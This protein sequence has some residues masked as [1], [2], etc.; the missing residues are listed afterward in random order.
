MHISAKFQLHLMASEEMFFFV[1]VFFC[2]CFFLIFFCKFSPSV[3]MATN[4]IQWLKNH[5]KLCVW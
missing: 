5:K 2:F 3:A 1:V 4:Q